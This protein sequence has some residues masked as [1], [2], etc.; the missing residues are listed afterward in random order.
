V[1]AQFLPGAETKDS[2]AGA[3]ERLGM[4]AG[5]VKT[6]VSRLRKRYRDA[7]R[8]EVA[9]TVADSAETDDEIRYLIAIFSE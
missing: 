6:E 2:L 9:R 3:A 7:L 5:A 4:T 8:E 1:L